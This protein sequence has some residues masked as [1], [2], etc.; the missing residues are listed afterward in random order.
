MEENKVSIEIPSE[1][2]YIRKVSSEILESLSPYGPDEKRLFDIK[3]CAE[4][5]IRNAIV[6]GNRADKKLHV[7]VS[8]WVEKDKLN[9]VVEDEGPG[10]DPEKVP[11]PTEKGNMFKESGRGVRLIRKLMDKVDFNEKGNRIR[12]EKALK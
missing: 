6:H 2:K 3:L 5:A 1:I 11:D 7:R 4:E 10:F 12:M 9:I 8:Y